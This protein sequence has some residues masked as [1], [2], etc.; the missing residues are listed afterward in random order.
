MRGTISADITTVYY[1]E[2]YRNQKIALELAG[3]EGAEDGVSAV[4]SYKEC[5]DRDDDFGYLGKGR[6]QTYKSQSDRP[7]GYDFLSYCPKELRPGRYYVEMRASKAVDYT[8]RL[9]EYTPYCPNNCTGGLGHG[10]CDCT[11][12]RCICKPGYYGDD[13]SDHPAVIV[14]DSYPFMEKSTTLAHQ[15]GG[16]PGRGTVFNQTCPEGYVV[17]GLTGSYYDY[18]NP[19]SYMG[20]LVRRVNLICQPLLGY[21]ILGRAAT[22]QKL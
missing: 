18:Y 2:I 6:L 21:G 3:P 13:C 17:V 11:I 19:K 22:R 9:S 20:Q 12:L 10:D 14:V 15:G 16:E 4:L 8:L 5:T 7:P 1:F